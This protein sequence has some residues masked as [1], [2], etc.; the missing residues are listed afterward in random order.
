MTEKTGVTR[1]RDIVEIEVTV[2][3]IFSIYV[4][5][6]VFLAVSMTCN[7]LWDSNTLKRRY[8]LFYVQKVIRTYKIFLFAFQTTRCDIKEH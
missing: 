5:P 7:F 8:E 4:N 1:S 3:L 6:E 2:L